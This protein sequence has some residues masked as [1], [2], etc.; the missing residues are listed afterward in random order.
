MTASKDTGLDR[1]ISRRTLFKGLAGSVAAVG[2]GGAVLNAGSAIARPPTL[3]QQFIRHVSTRQ[4]SPYVF[5]ATGPRTFDCSGLVQWAWNQ[6]GISVPRTAH[7]QW[8]SSMPLTFD[9][10]KAGDSIYFINSE[11]V[12]RH[13]LVWAGDG[14]GNIWQASNAYAACA[15]VMYG[16][17]PFTR[18]RIEYGRLINY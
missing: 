18:Q 11:G 3:G 10:L 8:K 16:P 12:A 15:C 17:M 14:T 4:G 2:I 7:N 13:T 1:T 6:M 5:G 9:Q